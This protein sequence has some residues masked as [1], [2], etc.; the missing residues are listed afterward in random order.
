M[1]ISGEIDLATAPAFEH[2]LCRHVQA[3][4]RLGVLDLDLSRVLFFS[5]IGLRILLKVA[6]TAGVRGVRLR[7]VGLSPAVA[8]VLDITDTRHQLDLDI[9]PQSGTVSG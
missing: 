5:A 1:V 6:E 3:P 4:G 7:V 2:F 9:A 8:H